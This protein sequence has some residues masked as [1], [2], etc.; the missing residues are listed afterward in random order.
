ML[1]ARAQRFE[2]GLGV[3]THLG[4]GLAG[5]E[6]LGLVDLAAELEVAAIG[7]RDL[8][9]RAPFL[10]QG[11]CPRRVRD[12]VGIE[13]HLLDLQESLIIRLKLLE[14]GECLASAIPFPHL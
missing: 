2:L 3:R 10:R 4:V 12:D 7:D 14:H 13:Q 1:V 9:Q 11:R 5:N 8:R 6:L